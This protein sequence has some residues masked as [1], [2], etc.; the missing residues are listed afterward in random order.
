MKIKKEYIILVAVI[1]A[2]SAYLLTRQT[3]RSQY[4]LPE[5]PEVPAKNITRME[6]SGPEHTVT[7][8]REDDRWRI[9]P[10]G[11][12]AADSKVR[13]MLEPLETLTLTALVS[14]S[15]DYSR[16]ELNPEKKITVKA[17]EGETLKREVAIGKSA[18][19]FRHT[20][21][22]IAG[23]PNVYHA[24]GNFRSA[25]ETDAVQLR[26]KTVLQFAASDIHTIRISAE[27]NSFTLVRGEA[28]IEKEPE[29]NAETPESVDA[30]I[31]WKTDDGR[32]ADS[33]EIDRLLGAL[34]LLECERF[35]DDRQKEDFQNPFYALELDGVTNT[36][37]L[38]IFPL[39]ETDADG[40]GEYP[41]ASSESDDPFILP[42][43][44][45]KN[46][47]PEIGDLVVAAETN[48]SETPG[49]AGD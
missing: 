8:R 38:E 27:D 31:V 4:E 18:P 42:E 24:R 11:H 1:V 17:W 45:V 16:Y 34:A 2:L 23:D 32:V 40:A 6:I 30:E 43:W 35:I 13:N 5:I 46:L 33:A 25:F 44:R 37:R 14:E 22:S 28:P 48:D 15:Q 47:T 26:D 20:F 9:E 19:S 29:N 12:L 3:D 7:I 49:L 39:P 21:V 10:R 41:A 36:Y